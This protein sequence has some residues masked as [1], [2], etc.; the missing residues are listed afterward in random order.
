MSI[1]GQMYIATQSREGD[2]EEFFA[3]ESQNF[4]PSLAVNVEK[5][6]HS[7]KSDILDCLQKEVNAIQSLDDVRQTLVGLR[8]CCT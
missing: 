4:P 5:M 3:H 2:L 8:C 6:Y 1:L 7:R